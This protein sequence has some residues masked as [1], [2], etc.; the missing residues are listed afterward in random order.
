MYEYHRIE[1]QDGFRMLSMQKV[2]N[3][4]TVKSEKK[5]NIR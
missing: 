5:P 2:E 1:K 3:D 4:A